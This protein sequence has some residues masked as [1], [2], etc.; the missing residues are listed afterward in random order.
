M[1][2]VGDLAGRRADRVTASLAGSLTARIVPILPVLGQWA[3][4]RLPPRMEF[5]TFGVARIQDHARSSAQR[6]TRGRSPDAPVGV[7]SQPTRGVVLTDD[8]ERG[9]RIGRPWPDPERV[10]D[11]PRADEG[12]GWG[13]ISLLS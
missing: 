4:G 13:R 7:G 11:R 3:E 12:P 8:R 10:L 5:S 1:M 9:D 2:P 6:A